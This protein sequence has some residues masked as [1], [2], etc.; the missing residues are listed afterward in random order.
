[1]E[2]Y[3]GQNE[4]QHNLVE[5]HFRDYLNSTIS[6]YGSGNVLVI[7]KG[8]RLHN[9]VIRFMGD[10]AVV[11]LCSS[12]HVL[13]LDAKLG[14][15]STLSIGRN[16]FINTVKPLSL[17]I[18]EGRNVILADNALISFG[19][20][21]DA[22]SGDIIV[23]NHCWL[24]EE[25]LVTAPARLGGGCVIGAFSRVSNLETDAFQTIVGSN[26]ILDGRSIHANDS[27]KNRGRGKGSI[28]R[29]YAR[30]IKMDCM[31]TLLPSTES[32]VG[33]AIIRSSAIRRQREIGG[34][35]LAVRRLRLLD[36]NPIEYAKLIK[37]R[38][39]SRLKRNN[40]VIGSPILNGSSIVFN[41]SN[42]TLV[43]DKGVVLKDSTISFLG[44][45]GTAY[46]GYADCP[47]HIAADISTDSVLVISE[48]C[49]TDGLLS[50]TASEGRNV[51]IGS[52]CRFGDGCWVRTSDQHGVYGFD[53]LKRT[54]PPKSTVIES[55]CRFGSHCHILKGTYVASGIDV[56]PFSVLSNRAYTGTGGSIRFGEYEELDGAM[57]SLESKLQIYQNKK[58]S[59]KMIVGIVLD[60]AGIKTE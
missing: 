41:G 32:L 1:M 12:P 20:T 13:S 21:L 42:N 50:I 28:S 51:I 54:N 33:S 2:H 7:E 57:A 6:F 23:G 46:L 22:S 25:S 3:T 48:G 31:K 43:C 17:V 55:D 14:D 37:S 49:R 53:S 35:S 26:R 39:E 16:T 45:N 24:G 56:D 10:N 18:G 8:V 47:H 59:S 11:Y 9:S 30:A 44:D 52:C 29:H 40:R 19:V 4:L 58:S 34:D 38:L 60:T 27:I 5:G 15:S 36:R